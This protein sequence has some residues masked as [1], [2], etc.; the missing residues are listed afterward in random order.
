MEPLITMDSK[1][2]DDNNTEAEP[3]LNIKNIVKASR[4][5]SLTLLGFSLTVI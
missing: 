3:S 1:E 4:H 2:E 5:I